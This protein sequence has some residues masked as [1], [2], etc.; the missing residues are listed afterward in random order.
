VFAKFAGIITSIPDCVLGG[1]TIF[2]FANVLASGIAL[3][4]TLNLHSRRV[5]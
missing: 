2:L 5:K 1:M 4:A 3:A